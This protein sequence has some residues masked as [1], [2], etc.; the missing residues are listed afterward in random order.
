MKTIKLFVLLKIK[1]HLLLCHQL[2]PPNNKI[3]Q[4]RLKLISSIRKPLSKIVN[5]SN[6]KIISSKK[7]MKT[8]KSNALIMR[9]A[10]TANL[11]IVQLQ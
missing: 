4:K 1:N 8:F 3:T 5:P 11:K 6:L 9:N 7:N 10:N 2:P